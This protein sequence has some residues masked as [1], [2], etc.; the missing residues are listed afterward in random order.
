MNSKQKKI[1]NFVL[2]PL[3]PWGDAMRSI[4]NEYGTGQGKL[5]GKQG[6]TVRDCDCDAIS[7]PGSAGSFSIVVTSR[8]AKLLT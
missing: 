1:Q 3:A 5:P 8:V 4:W 6:S 7:I 2:A